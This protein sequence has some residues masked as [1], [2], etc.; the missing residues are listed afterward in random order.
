MMVNAFL[1]KNHL[2]FVLEEWIFQELFLKLTD[3]FKYG[4]DMFHLAANFIHY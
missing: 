1:C 4:E 2:P 3:N